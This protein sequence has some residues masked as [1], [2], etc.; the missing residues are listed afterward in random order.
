MGAI[1]EKPSTLII[2]LVLVILLFGA[3]RL[4]DAARGI[5]RSLRILKSET[6]GLRGDDAKDDAAPDKPTQQA[7]VP[8]AVTAAPAP[9][10]PQQYAP[11]SGAPVYA[12][13][14]GQQPVTGQPNAQQPGQPQG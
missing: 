11:P 8:P 6:E 7:Y 3:K 12:P 10:A 4:P 2:I 14:A 1:F 9:Y 13:P 5:G